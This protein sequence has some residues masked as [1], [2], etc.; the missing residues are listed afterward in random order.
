MTFVIID[1]FSKISL[2]TK[3]CC[4]R[5]LSGR[6][7]QLSHMH[8]PAGW[9]TLRRA[10]LSGALESKG[11]GPKLDAL[12]NAIL[13]QQNHYFFAFNSIVKYHYNLLRNQYKRFHQ[14][15][16]CKKRFRD[17]YSHCPVS[18]IALNRACITENEK[19]EISQPDLS[20]I[21]EIQCMGLSNW[22]ICIPLRPFC[23][24]I[25][26]TFDFYTGEGQFLITPGK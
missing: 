7:T 25:F 9:S 6:L 5:W 20:E 8:R 4:C 26:P 3:A 12:K 2:E 15:F 16:P 22:T 18:G 14:T 21:Q 11:V 24:E 1:H 17:N 23:S 13:L 10:N 19:M